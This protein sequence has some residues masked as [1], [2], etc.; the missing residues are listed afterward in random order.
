VF[1]ADVREAIE[2]L[3][4]SDKGEDSR[5]FRTMLLRHGAVFRGLGF[6]TGEQFRINVPPEFNFAKLNFPPRRRSEKGRE[7]KYREVRAL[8]DLGVLRPPDAPASTN[9]VFVQKNTVDTNG[10]AA[11]RTATDHRM[12]KVYTK[13]DT[14]PVPAIKCIVNGLAAKKGFLTLDLRSG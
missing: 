13:N 10:I 8:L 3:H 7:T 12:I 1:D 6:A 5:D 4:L 2:G 9:N 14:Y 11:S